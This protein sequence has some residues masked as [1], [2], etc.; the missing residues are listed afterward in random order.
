M[1]LNQRGITLI[2]VLILGALVATAATYLIK[3][4][5]ESKKAFRT[6]F[7]KEEVGDVLKHITALLI[8]PARCSD[9]FQGYKVDNYSTFT[10]MENSDGVVYY[11]VDP[12]KVYGVNKGLLIKNMMLRNRLND[13]NANVTFFIEIAFKDEIYGHQTLLRGIPLNAAISG[14]RLFHCQYN[15]AE[16]AEIYLEKFCRGSGAVYVNGRCYIDSVQTNNCPDGKVMVGIQKSSTNDFLFS[17]I[18]EKFENVKATQTTCTD[19]VTEISL[20]DRQN[21][22]AELNEKFVQKM[23]SLNSVQCDAGNPFAAITQGAGGQYVLECQQ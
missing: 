20:E 1:R 22:C 5:T 13:P 19:F 6:T 15:I 23:F 14:G 7:A 8:D 3:A 16:V 21:A 18:C 4:N 2:H 12:Q 10:K 9:I 17:P 11:E